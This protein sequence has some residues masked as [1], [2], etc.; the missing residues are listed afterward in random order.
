MTT[1]GGG[2]QSRKYCELPKDQFSQLIVIGWHSSCRGTLVF[3]IVVSL[4]CEIK[5]AVG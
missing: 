1:Y 3:N 2:K 5:A 4:E